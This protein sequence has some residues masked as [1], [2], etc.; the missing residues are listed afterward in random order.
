MILTGISDEAG[1]LID[2]QIRATKELGWNCIEA[3]TVEVAGHPRGNIVDIPEEAF[4]IAREK[5]ATAGVS[6]YCVG[7]TIA[8]WG[9]K[10]DEPFDLTEVHR[11]VPRMQKLGCRFVRIMSYALRDGGDQ[12]A[13]ERFRRLREI[14]QVFR[15][16]GLQPLHENCM[17]YG[18]MGWRYTLELVENVP[19]LKL[20]FDTANPLVNRDLLNPSRP[21]Q[22][23]WAFW[24]HVR[25]H[26]E[27][28][29]VKDAIWSE[30]KQDAE[31]TLPGEGQGRVLDILADALQRGYDAGISIEPHLAVVFHDASVQSSPEE[32]YSSYVD[33]GRRLIKLV[34]ELRPAASRG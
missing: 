12:M 26:V 23:P 24:T 9:Q 4:E 17:N 10:I 19:G 1:A 18:G 30:S 8:N 7:S 25:E 16:A 2:T 28:I 27:H 32:Q 22:N 14:V 29:H 34:D 20:V 13:P 33:Y 15:D 5:L 6:V 31:Y 21:R 3:R 11:A